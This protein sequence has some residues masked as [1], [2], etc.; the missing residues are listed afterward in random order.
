MRKTQN[1]VNFPSG[2][3][4]IGNTGTHTMGQAV[5]FKSRMDHKLTQVKKLRRGNP[6]SQKTM[7][8]A[9]NK[10]YFLRTLM[11]FTSFHDFGSRKIE[12]P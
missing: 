1:K 8:Q 4:T 5:S 2:G 3:K 6:R 10:E 9:T 11:S 12:G 7:N